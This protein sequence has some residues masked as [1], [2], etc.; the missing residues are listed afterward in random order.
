MLEVSG[1]VVALTH[2]ELLLVGY[3]MRHPG[4]VCSRDELLS[5][6]WGCDDLSS[7]VVDVTVRRV[8]GKIPLP[9]IE[10]VRNIGYLFTTP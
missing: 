1:K 6:V 3:L 7:N 10:T 4:E 9:V 8:R 2:R 5:S